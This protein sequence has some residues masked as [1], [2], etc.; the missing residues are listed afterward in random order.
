MEWIEPIW[1]ITWRAVALAICVWYAFKIAKIIN[2]IE[3]EMKK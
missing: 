3:K 2:F 1:G